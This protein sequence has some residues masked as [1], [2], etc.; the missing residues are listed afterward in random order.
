MSDD[1]DCAESEALTEDTRPKKTR[2]N[3]MS[4]AANRTAI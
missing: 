4:Q 1:D 3:V 2:G